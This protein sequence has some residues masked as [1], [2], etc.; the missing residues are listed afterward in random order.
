M[1]PYIGRPQGLRCNAVEAAASTPTRARLRRRDQVGRRAVYGYP[2]G[3]PEGDLW[4]STSAD[5]ARVHAQV[6]WSLEPAGSTWGDDRGRCAPPG[7]RPS[8]YEMP[9]A[10]G[11][12]MRH[13]GV[14]EALRGTYAGDGL[15]AGHHRPPAA[16][17]ASPTV[18]LMP[19]HALRAT[20]T[21]W[22]TRACATTGA[23]THSRLLR[24]RTCDYS[25]WGVAAGHLRVQV[26]WSRAM[27]SGRDRGD[28][29]RGLQPHLRKVTTSGPTLSFQAASTTPAYYI[30]STDDERYYFDTTG[31]GNSAEHFATRTCC[32]SSS[33]RCAT[34]S[35]EMR[36][37]GF[38]FDLA[39][40][41]GPRS[42][43]R[44]GPARPRSST[45]SRQDPV[46]SQRQAHRR[47]VGPRSMGGYQVGNF[48]TSAGR[49][50]TASYRDTVRD[51]WK[52]DGGLIRWPT[53]PT[54]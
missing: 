35:T 16:S 36:V 2:L 6:R 42:S 38:R 45:S 23:T 18:E 21:T 5:S 1:A 41:A 26:R 9:R 34:G 8:L 10:S 11:L 48:P 51:Y 20:T 27:H 49:S 12:T 4:R 50:G 46:V 37:D 30:G 43:A 44:R 32:S 19:V 14:P 31:T 22:P 15:G 53:S 17:W 54:G 28:T 40:S 24:P 39:A 29:R 25:A 33:T 47:A 52:R 7:T 3:D 13:P